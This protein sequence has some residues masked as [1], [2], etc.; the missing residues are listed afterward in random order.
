MTRRIVHIFGA[1]DVG[2]AELRT[3]ELMKALA[4]DDV[5]FVFVTLSGQRGTLADQIE[6]HGGRVIPLKLGWSFPWRFI[7]LLRE[8]SVAVVDSHVAKFSGFILFLARLAAVPI[9]IAHFHSDGDGRSQGPHRR[10]YRRVMD[11]LVD[12]CSTDIVGVS[13]SALALG[14]GP[15]S[16]TDKRCAVLPNG[17]DR[18]QLRSGQMRRVLSRRDGVPLLV[19]VG[20]ASAEK[21][22][23][24]LPA[25]LSAYVGRYGEAE[26]VLLG[27]RD[28]RV[29]DR[30]RTAAKALGVE[31]RIRF[32]DAIPHVGDALVQADVLILTSVREGL[33]SVVIE[34]ASLG[35]PVVSS[36]V[37]GSVW[38]SEHLPGIVTLPLSADDQAWA[39]VVRSALV[40]DPTDRSSRA[41]EVFDE[42]IF[43]M[44]TAANRYR[45]LVGRR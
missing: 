9:R 14:Y 43:A 20:R 37:G 1:M 13:P 24:R 18:A 27:P 39:D 29:D 4:H 44:S 3:V 7:A 6:A 5:E 32:V 8:Q 12:I 41:A 30:V 11:L 23:E 15:R 21:N 34:A 25:I 33:P 22:L 16:R 28:A 45:E 40:H 42:S 35:V 17:V 2:G 31:T 10:L 36:D 19:S 26:L 38:I